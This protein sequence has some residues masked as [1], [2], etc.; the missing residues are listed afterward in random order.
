MVNESLAP[1]GDYQVGQVID[2]G[3][4]PVAEVVSRVRRIQEVMKALMKDGTHYGTIPGTPKPSLYQP[5]AELLCMTF[6][7]APQPHVEDLSAEDVI[8]YRVTMRAVSQ[9][10]GELLG[11]GIGECSSNETKYRWSRPTCDEEFAETPDDLKR[12]KWMRGKNGNYKAKQIRTSP[13]DI[14]NTILKMAY[15]RALISMTRT[16]LACSDQFAQDLEDLPEEIRESVVG[17]EAQAKPPI[18]PPQRKGNGNGAKKP[19]ESQAATAPGALLVTQAKVCTYDKKG[20]DG[21]P[22]GETATFYAVTF[23]DGREASTFDTKIF[24][25]AEK[26]R[27]ANVPVEMRR[28]ETKP[29]KF[30]LVEIMPAVAE[31][32]Q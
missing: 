20:K 17:D 29:G 18:Q 9:A 4:L 2:R 14:G 7:I 13:A 16:V 8:R 3:A 10:T 19:A 1:T 6:R 31:D 32:G 28:E 27:A 26:F 15:K 21:E 24:E 12:E 30:K 25:A 11:E 22:T 23:S 5:G